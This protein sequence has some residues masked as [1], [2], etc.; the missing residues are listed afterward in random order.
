M[1]WDVAGSGGTWGHDV[2][3]SDQAETVR[4]EVVLVTR[5]TA[6][7]PPNPL[8]AMREVVSSTFGMATY[9]ASTMATLIEQTVNQAVTTSVNAALDRLV[10]LIAEAV[11]ERI[12]LTRIVLDQVDL[13]RIVNQALDGLDL[14][15]LVID[16]VDIDA[17]VA[18]A[19]IEAV[20]D[21]VPIIPLANYVIDEIDLPQIIR[22]STGG[23]ASDAMNAVRL[24]GIGADR[25]V[26][27]LA[28]KVVLR[29]RERKVDAPGDPDSLRGHS[30]PDPVEGTSTADDGGATT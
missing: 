6:P 26:A 2:L 18:Q 29:R 24:Q 30:R 21:R 28:D 9:T 13:D 17:I 27:R 4:H 20:I 10:P 8:D 15:Q 11:I 19:D 25:L 1:G 12:D 14:T 3:M 22:S 16:R 7:R 5:P 23:V